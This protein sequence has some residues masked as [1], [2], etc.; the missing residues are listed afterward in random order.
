MIG[1][2]LEKIKKNFSMYTGIILLFTVGTFS[3][4]F[5]AA[6]QENSIKITERLSMGNYKNRL[7]ITLNNVTNVRE[8]QNI[9]KKF[10]GKS[11]LRINGSDSVVLVSYK[12]GLDY[13]YFITKGRFLN[14][15]ETKE[16]I[17][18]GYKNAI[19][20]FGTSDVLGKSVE[21]LSKEYKVVGILGNEI[22]KE[23][24]I[25]NNYIALGSVDEFFDF[26][27]DN[28][29]L[30]FSLY[31]KNEK[32]IEIAKELELELKK[33][34]KNIYFEISDWKENK[35]E[36]T[37][38]KEQIILFNGIIFI[39]I[40]FTSFQ[41]GIFNYRLKKKDYKSLLVTGYSKSDIGILISIENFIIVL[42]GTIIGIGLFFL[43]EEK[44][45]IILNKYE[46]FNSF[47]LNLRGVI[48]SLVINILAS[49]ILSCTMILKIN[50]GQIKD[51]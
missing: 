13:D 28:G 37:V 7:N 47:N 45:S 21:V 34:D 33:V 18:L 1:F 20:L 3:L 43:L 9:I 51:I 17:V 42:I 2:T 10:Q 38:T 48:Y 22:S 27:S 12:D 49:I 40:L 32:P 15:N 14:P 41:I 39:I 16:E 29:K 31:D 50:K 24:D 44:L 46:Y 5:I 19:D 26:C 11:T 25:Y 8:V 30:S 35:S 36:L 6:I 23:L 4:C